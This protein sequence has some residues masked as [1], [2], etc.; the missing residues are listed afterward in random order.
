ML[1]WE[2]IFFFFLFDVI[3]YFT[4]LALTT[5]HLLKFDHRLVLILASLDSERCI[6]MS[7]VIHVGVWRAH[8]EGIRFIFES[9]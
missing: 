2:L 7:H 3:G 1:S 4:E 9:S 5:V 8:I 6:V